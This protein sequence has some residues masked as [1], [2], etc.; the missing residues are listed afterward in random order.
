MHLE[1]GIAIDVVA[2]AL[3]LVTGG[4]LRTLLPQPAVHALMAL[5]GA[6]LGVGG[7]LMLHQVSAASWIAAPVVLASVAPLH[8]R[9]L[10]AGEGPF[11]T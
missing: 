5:A 3:A 11:R 4:R 8:V 1:A 6:G 10:F 7:L 9:A 2:G